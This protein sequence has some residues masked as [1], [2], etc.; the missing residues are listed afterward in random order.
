MNF[1]GKEGLQIFQSRQNQEWNPGP[2]GWKAEILPLRQPLLK[3][4]CVHWE[5]W[6]GSQQ[7][8]SPGVSRPNQNNARYQS[9]TPLRSERK[10]FGYCFRFSKGMHCGG[11]AY[12]H[13]C[14]KCDGSHFP[15]NCSFRGQTPTANTIPQTK[16]H[17][18]KA[19]QPI[20]N[21]NKQPH[22]N[23]RSR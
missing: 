10:P 15:T 18:N 23:T 6:M 19:Q 4:D 20:P 12:K 3:W 8:P 1:S 16:G 5:L 13:Q 14:H 7:S 22:G 9:N 17:H 2:L 21:P 11:C